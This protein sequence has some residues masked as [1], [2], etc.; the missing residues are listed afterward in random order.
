MQTCIYSTDSHIHKPSVCF[1]LILIRRA[2]CSIFFLFTLTLL[3]TTRTHE[4]FC[5]W[6]FLLSHT[7]YVLLFLSF[8]PI[9][10]YSYMKILNIF[11]L[12]LRKTFYSAFSA[13]TIYTVDNFALREYFFSYKIFFSQPSRRGK[14]NKKFYIAKKKK[15]ITVGESEK[16]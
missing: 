4:S 11:S 1:M 14:R 6:V 16:N 12:A 2:F 7:D 13:W 10:L 8:P 9:V 15:I 3:C 5:V